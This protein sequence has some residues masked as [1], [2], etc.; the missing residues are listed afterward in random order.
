MTLPVRE[1]RFTCLYVSE[2]Q[3]D[4]QNAQCR[5]LPWL[6]TRLY[7]AGPVI[8]ENTLYMLRLLALDT[9]PFCFKVE[10]ARCYRS[11]PSSPLICATAG[12]SNASTHGRSQNWQEAQ[13]Q[14]FLTHILP[15]SPFYASTYG[16]CP[17]ADWRNW[18]LMDKTRMMDNFD[19][20]NT[21]G[22]AKAAALDV[23]RAGE[24]VLTFGP[25]VGDVT[26]GL[27]P[28]CWANRGIFIASTAERL[29]WSG[30]VMAKVLPGPLWQRQRV[31]LFLR[32]NSNLYASV[33]SRRITFAFY[34]LLRPFE[35]HIR[36][37]NQY[38]PTILA[39]A[40]DAV[41][42]GVGA[43]KRRPGHSPRQGLLGGRDPRSTG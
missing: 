18:P 29:R 7:R 20:L 9:T 37:L 43:A 6:Q 39:T 8:R 32:A 1:I 38:Q 27:C 22:V 36:R 4:A 28:A 12:S 40:V 35:E 16:G 15:M 33:Q 26:V 11:F 25:M 3:S 31:G 30:A 42:V 24:A 21:L 34:D 13:V 19:A 41:A 17:L 14:R 5:R 10:P 23:A 2:C